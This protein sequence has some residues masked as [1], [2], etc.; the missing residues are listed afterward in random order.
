M[1]KMK[2]HAKAADKKL[3]V[4]KYNRIK[5]GLFCWTPD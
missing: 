1:K 4:P 5:S 2:V 3:N